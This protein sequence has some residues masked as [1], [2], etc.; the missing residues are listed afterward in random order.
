MV[1]IDI[2][3]ILDRNRIFVDEK[4]N[5]SVDTTAKGRDIENVTV[6]LSCPQGG[7]FLPASGLSNVIGVL[8]STFTPNPT[9][10]IA[11]IYYITVTASKTG[12]QASSK[13]VEIVVEPRPVEHWVPDKEYGTMNYAIRERIL[14]AIQSILDS[15]PELYPSTG[16]TDR[17]VYLNGFSYATRDFPQ[18]VITGGTVATRRTD[19]ANYVGSSLPGQYPSEQ[20]HLSHGGWHDMVL[21]VTAI[22][23]SKGL[24]EKLLDKVI[25]AIWAHKRWSLYADDGIL[26]LDVSGGPETTQ[27]YGAQL[28]YAGAIRISCAA[29]WFLKD[30]AAKTMSQLNVQEQIA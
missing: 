15:D 10:A 13:V 9:A 16:A 24:Q 6:A 22:A 23:E 25:M 8:T 19:L 29:E 5:I 27:P 1:P 26:I 17:P 28:L 30:V 20:A 11:V 7:T 3:I 12:L 2:N 14:K 21:T 18:I 4:I